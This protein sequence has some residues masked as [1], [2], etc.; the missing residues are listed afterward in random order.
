[1]SFRESQSPSV[2]MLLSNAY[3]PD[4]RVRQEGLALLEMGCRV[5]ILAWDRDLKACPAET[6]E[7]IEVQRVLL[8]SVHGRGATQL[9]FYALLYLQMFSKAW[10]TGFDVIHCHDLDMLPLGFILGKL[11]RKPIVYDA[12]ENFTDM[13]GTNVPSALRRGLEWLEDFLIRRTDLLITVGEK[14]RG[15]FAKRRA[16]RSV[17]VGN[18]K[19]VEDYS[20]SEGQNLELRR[21]FGIPEGAL[22]IACIT[23]L[24]KDRKLEELLAAVDASPDV[25]VIIGGKGELEDWV[26]ERAAKNPRIVYVGFVPVTEIPAYT[27]AADIIYYGFDPESPNARFSSPNKLFEALAAGKPIITGDFGEIADVVRHGSC[28]LILSRYSVPE[29]QTAFMKLGDPASLRRLAQNAKQ[30]GALA[31]NWEVGEQILFQEYSLLLP[32]GRLSH[33]QMH[34]TDPLGAANSAEARIA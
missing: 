31:M 25:Y 16:C 24:L 12:H 19:R 2:L 23:Q 13:L 18:W 27:C 6:L 30:M 3:D 28:G 8:A 1:M 15:H 21:R 10:R 4:P 22:L 9:F 5:R 33:P 26:R 14:L 17:V 32:A 20:R 7:G 11:K 29:I 34:G